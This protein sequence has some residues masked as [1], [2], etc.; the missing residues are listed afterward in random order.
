M[1]I[2]TKN[3]LFVDKSVICDELEPW[4]R[5]DNVMRQWAVLAGFEKDMENYEKLKEQHE[6]DLY[7]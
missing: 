3:V 6:Q 4:Q 1:N 5:L 2:Y 7:R